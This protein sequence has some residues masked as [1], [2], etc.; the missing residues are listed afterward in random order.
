MREIKFRGQTFDTKEWVTGYYFEVTDGK[1]VTYEGEFSRPNKCFIM[2][3]D[4]TKFEVIPESV[5]QYLGTIDNQEIWS[6]SIIFDGMNYHTI[7]LTIKKHT[8]QGHGD[9]LYTYSIN[10]FGNYGL[11]NTIK[12]V[13]STFENKELLGDK[14]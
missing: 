1:T 14:I 13:G 10:L 9:C 2:Q 12:V 11:G 4:Y 3:D 7:D 8:Q 5:S 6:N